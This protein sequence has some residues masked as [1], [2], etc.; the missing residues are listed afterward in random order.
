MMI[1]HG[2]QN[3]K[4]DILDNTFVL[5]LNHRCAVAQSCV[6][7]NRL[8][9]E[10]GKIRPLADPIS[11]NR[12]I[13]NLKQ[14]ITSARRPPVQNFVQIRPLGASRQRDEI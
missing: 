5:S 8:S 1:L 11:L 3:A 10:N 13:K 4:N 14:V 2:R 7:S 12:S 6:N 9:M